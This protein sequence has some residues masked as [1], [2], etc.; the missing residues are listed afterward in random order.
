MRNHFSFERGG[1]YP[2]LVSDIT[3]GAQ[4]SYS[5]RRRWQNVFSV[6]IENSPK[7]YN[8][9]I[10]VS[11]APYSGVVVKFGPSQL[12]VFESEGFWLKIWSGH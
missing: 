8:C 11:V 3:E 4:Y 5:K 10:Q 1:S 2:S 7:C 9:M 6:R 12:H